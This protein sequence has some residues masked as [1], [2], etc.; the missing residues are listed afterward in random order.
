M[1]HLVFQHRKGS[2]NIGDRECCP[3]YWLPFDAKK[4]VQSLKETVPPCDIAIF[5]GGQI[6]SSVVEAVVSRADAARHC[7]TWAIGLQAAKRRVE[8]SDRFQ[9]RMS[10]IGCRDTG[11]K[12]TEYVPCATCLIPAMA[13]S[14]PP[15]HEVVMYLHSGKSD[16]VQRPDGLPLRTNHYGTLEEA[17]AFI[18]SGETVVTNS[19]HGTYWAMLMGR[20]VIC[21][22]FSHKFSGFARMPLLSDPTNWLG[23]LDRAHAVPGYRDECIAANHTFRDKVMNLV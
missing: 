19:F 14:A 23:D 7:V 12:G 9:A 11:I 20:K 5:G 6:Y 21:L 1:V 18:A 17:L 2:R 8:G 22:P 4:T 13:T 16:D 10:L 15:T 3:A